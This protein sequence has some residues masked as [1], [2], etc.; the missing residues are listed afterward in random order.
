MTVVERQLSPAARAALT[1]AGWTEERSIGHAD[2]VRPLLRDG[3]LPADAAVRFLSS[4][5]NLRVTFPNPRQTGSFDDL[6]FDVELAVSRTF[7]TWVDFWGGIAGE[8]LTLVGEWAD[9]SMALCIGP[10]GRTYAGRDDLL[11]AIGRDPWDALN[12]VVAGGEFAVLNDAD[13]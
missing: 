13:P 8:P 12:G 10:S 2:V 7:K 4:V 5:G 6:H 3:Y 9:G 11:L 1:A